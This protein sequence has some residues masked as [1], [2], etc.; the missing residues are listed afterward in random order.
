MDLCGFGRS[1]LSTI[2]L[3][4]GA[5]TSLWCVPSGRE[6]GLQEQAQKGGEMSDI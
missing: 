2:V 3:R 5:R 1:V 4:P 6:L